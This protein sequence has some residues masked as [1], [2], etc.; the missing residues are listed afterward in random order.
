MKRFC[1]FTG[2]SIVAL[3]IALLAAFFI[4]PSILGG[5]VH[6]GKVEDGRYFVVGK[7]HRFTEVTEL[8]WQIEQYL[9]CSFPWLPVMLIWLGV[10][11]SSA[12]DRDKEPK[13]ET[14]AKNAILGFSAF[15]G[16]VAGTG[17]LALIR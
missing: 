6:G 8:Q 14:T 5:D 13:L 7:G 15:L 10:G 2:R 16:A 4:Y 11:L 1:R 17:I 9:E 3:A 12:P